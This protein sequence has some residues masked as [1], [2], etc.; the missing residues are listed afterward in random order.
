MAERITNEDLELL[1][2][3]GV[4][5]APAASGGRSAR[6]Q[7][8]IAGF[9]D[10]LRFSRNT[11]GRRST[12]RTAIFLNGFTLRVKMNSASGFRLGARGG[13]VLWCLQNERG[14]LL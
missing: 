2:E 14:T 4:D 1:R 13:G 6:E 10:I 12:A 7:R 8:I 3:L 9:E 5:A 11:A